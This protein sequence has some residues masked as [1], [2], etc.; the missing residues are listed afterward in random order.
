MTMCLHIP[1]FYPGS[2]WD[3]LI[4]PPLRYVKGLVPITTG[5]AV[6]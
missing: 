4:G 1:P 6:S 5:C 3:K 2:F